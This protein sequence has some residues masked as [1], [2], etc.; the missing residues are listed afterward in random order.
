MKNDTM[1]IVKLVCLILFLGL[2]LP[3][4]GLATRPLWEAGVGFFTFKLPHYRGS[5]Q[6]RNFY[7]PAPHFIYRGDKVQ[8]ENGYIMGRFLKWGRLRLNLSFFLGLAVSSDENEA[9][10]GMDDLDFTFE[11]GPMANIDLWKSQSHDMFFTFNIP[12]R[13]SFSTDFRKIDYVG[14]FTVPFINFAVAPQATDLRLGIEFA[15]AYMQ[16][17]KKYHN[18]FYGVEPK[19]ATDTRAAYSAKAGYSGTQFSLI[20]SRRFGN[21]MV[22]PFMRYDYLKST[23][24]SDSPLVKTHHYFVYGMGISWFFLKS[25]REQTGTLIR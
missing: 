7:L 11:V 2:T 25:K 9:R 8:A 16:A 21:V 1:K 22:I 20:L 5:N 3:H 19:F 18:Y 10:K 14:I 17:S 4:K 15:I 6:D 24:F 12:I 23:A 13:P